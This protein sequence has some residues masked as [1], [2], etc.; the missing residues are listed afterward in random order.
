M[1]ARPALA[2]L[3]ACMLLGCPSAPAAD[4]AAASDDR[5]AHAPPDAVT[6]DAPAI[7]A[8]PPPPPT[9]EPGLHDVTI[10]ESRRIVPGA[11][12]PAEAMAQTSNNNLDV[13]RFEGRVYLAFRT[14]P[15]HYA[16]PEVRLHLV[17]SADEITW[18]FE[19]SFM[20]A[21]D[22]REPRF[23]EVN[24]RLFLYMAELGTNPGDFEPMGTLVSERASDGSWSEPESI[25][26]LTNAI[27]WR[28]RTETIDGT[29]THFMTAYY[30]G[31]MIYDFLESPMI[32]VELLVTSDGR[33]FTPFDPA[34]RTLYVGGASETD[35]SIG[36]DGRLFGVMRNEA[37]D[38]ESGFGSR[39]C[40]AEPG[41]L[42]EWTC[43]SDPKK[44]DSPLMFF[45]DGEHYLIG[46]RNVTSTGNYDLMSGARTHIRQAVLN[47]GAYRSAPKR[48][49]L[50]RYVQG[51]DRFAF[52]LD[53][54]SRGDTCFPGRLDGS[55]PDDVV[56]YNYSSDPDGPDV[57]WGVGQEGPTYIDRHVLHFTR[58]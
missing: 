41:H 52:I 30:G 9:S 14:G 29:P 16:S 49:S 3:V 25:P 58:R 12:L 24:G 1:R 39:V 38:A 13:I 32:R 37:G 56:V 42:A 50:W 20:R 22:L 5:D 43:V 48:C 11:G 33:T 44:Y 31:E 40:R 55:T 2:S 23:L 35:F 54:P 45:H 28:T 36:P 34:H 6:L 51:E 53:L 18:D 21:T 8:G 7:D 19:R 46:R 47:Q 4:D 57:P 27:G 26:E 17:S 10:V 15:S